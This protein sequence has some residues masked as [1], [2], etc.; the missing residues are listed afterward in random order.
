MF[1]IPLPIVVKVFPVSLANRF[2]TNC[3]Y[4]FVRENALVLSEAI[5]YKVFLGKPSIKQLMKID[6]NFPTGEWGLGQFN[7]FSPQDPENTKRLQKVNSPSCLTCPYAITGKLV[8]ASATNYSVEVNCP[9]TC[10]TKNV[11][12]LIT[13]KHCSTQLSFSSHLSNLQHQLINP[14]FKHFA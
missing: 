1:P 4:L 6:E 11:I 2:W 5:K 10:D 12:Y 14:D 3:A 8:K 9:V 13:C 7:L